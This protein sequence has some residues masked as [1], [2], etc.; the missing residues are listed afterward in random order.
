VGL[1]PLIR[2]EFNESK[3]WCKALEYACKGIP[4][5]ASDVGQ[6]P[7]WLGDSDAGLLVHGHQKWDEVLEQTLDAGWRQ[8]A[9]D[10]AYAK[11]S[12]WTIDKHAHLWAAVYSEDY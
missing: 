10:A 7:Q 6:Y 5:V 12:D 1:A 8:K 9:A 11:A 4:I 2:C 3:S